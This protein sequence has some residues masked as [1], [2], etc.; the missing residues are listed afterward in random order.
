[1]KK[2]IFLIVPLLFF[3]CE[4]IR[5]QDTLQNE[6]TKNPV[7]R[8]KKFFIGP[9]VGI[10]LT[11]NSLDNYSVVPSVVLGYKNLMFT[12]GPK[13]FFER[14][15]GAD[16]TPFKFFGFN[17]DLRYVFRKPGSRFRYFVNVNVDYL[18]EEYSGK[19]F[20]YDL[21]SVNFTPY[22]QKYADQTLCL[23]AG[24]GFQLKIYK[25]LHFSMNAGAGCYFYGVEDT[26]FDT[27][28]GEIIYQSK[29]KLSANSGVSGLLSVGFFYVFYP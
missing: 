18:T 23:N 22:D 15:T 2:I 19:V 25:G 21:G 16:G 8:E 11:Q 4:K 20:S 5:G 14:V 3:F 6:L 24:I 17:T 13:A 9:S 29:E 10:H 27:T 12:A 1:M 26:W 7:G 28:S